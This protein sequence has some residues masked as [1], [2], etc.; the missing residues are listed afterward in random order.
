LFYLNQSESKLKQQQNRRYHLQRTKIQETMS[1]YAN[2]AQ[3]THKTVPFTVNLTTLKTNFV[4][5]LIFLQE[6]HKPSKLSDVQLLIQKLNHE[7]L[8]SPEDALKPK[9]MKRSD[10]LLKGIIS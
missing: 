9:S 6:T 7:L 4:H 3:V 5:E 10:Q 2:K 1:E 8:L